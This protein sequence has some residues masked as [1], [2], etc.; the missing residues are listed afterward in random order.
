MTKRFSYKRGI[1]DWKF[2]RYNLSE[3]TDVTKENQDINS[4]ILKLT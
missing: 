1:Y 3:I 4:T 2:I